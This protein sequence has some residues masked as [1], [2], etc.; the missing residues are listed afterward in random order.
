MSQGVQGYLQRQGPQDIKGREMEEKMKVAELIAEA[1]LLEQKEMIQ[2]EAE[3]L[4]IKERLAKIQAKL[5]ACNN[6][7]LESGN[8]RSNSNP[9]YE[10]MDDARIVAKIE[11]EQ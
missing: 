3:M 9:H 11:I 1:W 5:E 10:V 7:E 8:E 4:K 2:N 6:M